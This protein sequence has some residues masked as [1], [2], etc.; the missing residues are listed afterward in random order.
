[1]ATLYDAQSGEVL[2]HHLEIADTFWTRFK[3]LQLRKSLPSGHGLLIK[4]CSSL[5][6][7]FMR[8][9]IDVIMLDADKVVVGIRKNLRPWRMLICH[10]STTQVVEVCAGTLRLRVGM[11]LS[12]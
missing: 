7:C 10:R 3:G 9:A 12:W 6:T 5:H 1:M 8:F 2:L 4:P 11:Q